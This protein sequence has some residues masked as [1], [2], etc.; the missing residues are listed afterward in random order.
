[1]QL[2]HQVGRLEWKIT[3]KYKAAR[4]GQLIASTP[5]S[6]VFSWLCLAQ[7]GLVLG[8]GPNICFLDW[9]WYWSFALCKDFMNTW[10]VKMNTC[11]PADLS[12]CWWC[13]HF[14]SVKLYLFIIYSHLW[15]IWCAAFNAKCDICSVQDFI[16]TG[17]EL[18]STNVCADCKIPS[19]TFCEHYSCETE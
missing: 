19:C 5:P 7:F 2:G 17:S 9:V 12:W 4:G 16:V 18:L 14:S 6:V 15:F 11:K 1:M 13:W 3:F 10:C 8:Q